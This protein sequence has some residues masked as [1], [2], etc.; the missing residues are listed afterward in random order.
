MRETMKTTPILDMSDYNN[1]YLAGLL[2]Y[3][4]FTENGSTEL[5]IRNRASPDQKKWVKFIFSTARTLDWALG[6]LVL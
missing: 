2:D 3:S 1:K 6:P 4:H 5:L